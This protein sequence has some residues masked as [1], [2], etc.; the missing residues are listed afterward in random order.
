M[1]FPWYEE[2]AGTSN[3]TQ[4]DILKN[5]PV[6]VIIDKDE[7]P[8]FK[9]QGAKYD[10]IVMTQACDLENNK[11]DYVTLCPV[12]PLENVIK[13]IAGQENSD[14][15][16][17]GLSSKQK[18]IPERIVDRLKKG[19]YL[20]FYLLNQHKGTA[21]E[22]YRVVILKQMFQVPVAAMKKLISS[23]EEPIRVRLLPPYRE[24]L[25]QAY[26]NTFSRIGLPLNINVSETVSFT[27]NG[28]VLIR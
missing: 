25:A 24:H 5:F 22:G 14:L 23:H 9:P 4:G 12:E 8:F 7:Y 17:S 28:E 21:N 10:V 18:K 2:V 26:A 27:D 6:P 3:V 1:S 15:N 11:V 16:Y 19:E 20:N 13:A